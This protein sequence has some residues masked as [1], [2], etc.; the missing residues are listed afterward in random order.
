[1]A[2]TP[3]PGG[4]PIRQAPSFRDMPQMPIQQGLAGDLGQAANQVGGEIDNYNDREGKLRKLIADRQDALAIQDAKNYWLQKEQE[5]SDARNTRQE[6]GETREQETYDREGK[7]REDLKS[8]TSDFYNAY[9]QLA[10]ELTPE[11]RK[12]QSKGLLAQWGGQSPD[13]FLQDM[14]KPKGSQARPRYIRTEDNN[15]IMYDKDNP[16]G[17]LLLDPQ[18]GRPVVGEQGLKTF[19]HS[20]GIGTIS[21]YTGDVGDTGKAPKVGSGQRLSVREKLGTLRLARKQMERVQEAFKK[22]TLAFGP[23]GAGRWPSEQ[24]KLFDAATD[25]ARQTVR[26]LSRT[27]GE[28]AM[29]DFETRLAQAQIPNRNNYETVTQAQI[30]ALFDLIDLVEEDFGKISKEFGGDYTAG[31]EAKTKSPGKYVPTPGSQPK[32]TDTDPLGLGL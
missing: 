22:N 21:R 28:G 15:W 17:T 14:Y 19:E 31:S 12:S 5:L 24:G 18:T 27:K 13:K 20:T 32:K 9:N 25:A 16:Q 29:S 10:P 2:Q 6:A 4:M 30:D 7:E 26:Q 11:Q 23:F 8:R 1:M 3:F